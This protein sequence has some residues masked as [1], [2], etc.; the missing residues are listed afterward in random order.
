VTRTSGRMNPAAFPGQRC[1]L[2]RLRLTR[3]ACSDRRSD[4]APF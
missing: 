4:R 2:A 1:R 3:L